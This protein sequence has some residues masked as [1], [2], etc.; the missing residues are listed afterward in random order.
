MDVC[1]VRVHHAL[2]KRA[3]AA[4]SPNRDAAVPTS[5]RAKVADSWLCTT[6]P[7]ATSYQDGL[8]PR[9]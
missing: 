7:K 2:E 1:G 8:P 6:R 5:G 9:A 4:P 3:W